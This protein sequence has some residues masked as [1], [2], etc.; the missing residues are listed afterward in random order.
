M[1]HTVGL[2]II[3]YNE[4]HW[5]PAIQELAGQQ[6]L[7]EFSPAYMLDICSA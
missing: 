3:K 4:T 1:L 7:L 6:H 2:S 5:I